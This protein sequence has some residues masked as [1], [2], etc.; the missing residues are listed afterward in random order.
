MELAAGEER[1]RS[2]WAVWGSGQRAWGHRLFGGSYWGAIPGGTPIASHPARLPRPERCRERA[3][4]A[5][6]GRGFPL[7]LSPGLPRGGSEKSSSASP[8]T[9]GLCAKMC[10]RAAGT[11]GAH[12]RAEKFRL[13]LS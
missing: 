1:P 7:L 4:C 2:T 13:L 6:R 12:P 11:A 8:E 10:W 5:R 9:W 3:S